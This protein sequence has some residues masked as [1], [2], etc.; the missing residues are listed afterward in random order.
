MGRRAKPRRG[1]EQRNHTQAA[2]LSV[3]LRDLPRARC[4]APHKVKHRSLKAAETAAE[5]QWW[6]DHRI[7][8]PYPCGDHYHLTSHRETSDA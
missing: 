4:L 1:R 7:L 5:K 6:S 8:T 3:A 2:A